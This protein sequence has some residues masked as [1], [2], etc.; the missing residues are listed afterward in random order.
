MAKKTGG[1]KGTNAPKTE[2][3][4]APKAPATAAQAVANTNGAA[5]PNYSEQYRKDMQKLP[6]HLRVTTKLRRAMERLADYVKVATRFDDKAEELSKAAGLTILK[7]SELIKMADTN[8]KDAIEA[9]ERIPHDYTPPRKLGGA[10]AAK[11]GTST[12]SA[13]AAGDTVAIR[14]KRRAAYTD[15]LSATEMT[16]LV[17][18]ESRKNK[19]VCVTEGGVKVFIPKAHVEKVGTATLEQAEAPAAGGEQP[20]A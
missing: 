6:I 17:V 10:A 18:H 12:A 15:D 5:K 7:P 8:I 14:E 13:I 19:L 9:L 11:A 3:P 16:K 20:Q 2:T 1:N 4:K